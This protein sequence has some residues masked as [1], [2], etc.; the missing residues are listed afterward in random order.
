MN[1]AGL[2][3]T[4]LAPLGVLALV[5]WA[6]ATARRNAG[7]VD[8]FWSLFFLLAALVYAQGAGG[9]SARATVVLGL[10]A[11]WAF[12]LAGHLAVRNWNAPEDHRYVQI[13]AR[14]EPGFTWKSVYLVFGL[15]AVLAW[16]IS[17]PLAGAIASPAPLGFLDAIGA[18]L[19]ATGLAIEAI[20]DYQLARFKA[21]PANARAVMDRGLW[22]YSRHPNYFGEFCVWWG[23]YAIAIAAGAEW[24]VFAPFLMSVLLLRVSGVALLER[25]IGD[26]RPAYRQYIARTNAFFPGPARGP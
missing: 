1:A 20:A 6:V 11:A 26:R 19:A 5:A 3:L 17:A 16:I 23:F 12:R 18:V 24:T 10:V 8:I 2:W 15:Q 22:R 13:R 9:H 25:D 7:L 4:A 14:N 21:D